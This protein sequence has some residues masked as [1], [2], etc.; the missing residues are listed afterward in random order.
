LIQR[1]NPL[2]KCADVAAS[3]DQWGVRSRSA[4]GLEGSAE[5][6]SSFFAFGDHPGKKEV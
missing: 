3:D 5:G 4:K 2:F 1:D 6:G